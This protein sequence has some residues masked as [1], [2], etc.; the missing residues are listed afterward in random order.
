MAQ[1]TTEVSSL[2]DQIQR[3]ILEMGGKTTGVILVGQ[4]PHNEQAKGRFTIR[5]QYL[6]TNNST[7]G[8]FSTQLKIN[9]GQQYAETY[10]VFIN[11]LLQFVYIFIGSCQ[12]LL[13]IC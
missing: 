6:S 3:N 9:K 12:I 2:V 1:L 7:K 11:C 10:F 5:L 13:C 4:P 8:V